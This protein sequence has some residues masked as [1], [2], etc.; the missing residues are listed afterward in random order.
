MMYHSYRAANI[1]CNFTKGMTQREQRDGMV[2]TIHVSSCFTELVYDYQ[3]T[4]VRYIY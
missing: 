3:F 1:K 4:L 2:D